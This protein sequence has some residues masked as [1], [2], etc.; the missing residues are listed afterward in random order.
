MNSKSK[1]I[2]II[3]IILWGF[4]SYPQKDVFVLV[5]VSGNPTMNP[6]YSSISRNERIEALD[7]VKDM[8][9]NEFDSMKYPAWQ[10]F[11]LKDIFEQNYNSRGNTIV[12]Q[13]SILA[14]IP[15]G[16]K[17]TYKNFKIYELNSPKMDVKT[18]FNLAH[19]LTYTDQ[20]TF[21]NLATAKTA[22]IAAAAGISSYYLIKIVGLGGDQTGSQLLDQNEKKYILNFESAAN[23]ESLGSLFLKNNKPYS[24]VFK[25]VDIA[26]F[27]NQIKK[28]A[29]GTITKSNVE[30]A[31]IKIIKPTGT[32]EKPAKF[33]KSDPVKISWICLGNDPKTKFSVRL[34]NLQTSKSITE[35]V[36]GF[37]TSVNLSQGTYRASV[38][39]KGLSSSK[40]EIIRVS[41]GGGGIW[42]FVL[43]CLVGLVYYLLKKDPFGWKAK[44]TKEKI[45]NAEEIT[46]DFDNY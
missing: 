24:I 20:L 31:R 12:T 10:S 8:I 14:I 33:S 15:F 46:G 6:A 9:L 39:S 4:N 36:N 29:R 2:L 42:F 45:K 19:T 25:K 17:N 28:S 38:S 37:S 5:D 16:E 44:K 27:Q 34:T 41:G 3:S 30:K 22:D 7:L 11:K 26:G 13:N 32:T 21:E 35:K 18:A 23:T 43:L 40:P 1:F